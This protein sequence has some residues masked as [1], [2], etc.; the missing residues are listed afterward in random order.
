MQTMLRPSTRRLLSSRNLEA[1]AVASRTQL[2]DVIA[3]FLQEIPADITQ[4]F[5]WD[6][7]FIKDVFVG[8]KIMFDE[9]TLKTADDPTKSVRI[10]NSNQFA[11][12][13]LGLF[14][15]QMKK[16]SFNVIGRDRFIITA[17]V[18]VKLIEIILQ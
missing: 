10:A 5:L 14:L 11:A 13:M 12:P 16:Y 9:A 8:N 3:M 6:V 7:L 15:Q 17:C 4:V 1:K 18:A 2:L